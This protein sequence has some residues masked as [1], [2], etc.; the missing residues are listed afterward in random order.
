[1]LSFELL[2]DWMSAEKKDFTAWVETKYWIID[3]CLKSKFLKRYLITDKNM[4]AFQ[5]SSA[6]TS[7]RLVNKV[8]MCGALFAGVAFVGY[9]IVKNAVKKNRNKSDQGNYLCA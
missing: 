8:A 4:S 2:K 3:R 5:P 9:R 6:A 1:M 7:D